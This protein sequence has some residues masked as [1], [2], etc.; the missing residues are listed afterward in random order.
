MLHMS[1]THI[2]L[3]VMCICA[4]KRK[5]CAYISRSNN[6]RLSKNILQCDSINMTTVTIFAY[7]HIHLQMLFQLF[8]GTRDQW[9]RKTHLRTMICVDVLV[10]LD[11]HTCLECIHI[12]SVTYARVLLK[13]IKSSSG[14]TYIPLRLSLFK[15]NQV[16]TH[17]FTRFY[18][19]S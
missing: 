18:R 1:V 9:I 3:W 12:Y 6:S 7:L 19:L 2:H 4:Q 10:L 15:A 14:F 8:R 17:V 16:S 5:L 13:R 11:K